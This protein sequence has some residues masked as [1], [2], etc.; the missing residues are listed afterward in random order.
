MKQVLQSKFLLGSLSSIIALHDFTSTRHGC[1][2]STYTELLVKGSLT[3]QPWVS[4]K[5]GCRFGADGSQQR[6]GHCFT[7]MCSH[8]SSDVSHSS[9]S[10]LLCLQLQNGLNAYSDLEGPFMK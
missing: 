4:A 8:H 10:I 6:L 3:L 7:M 9:G 2:A 1:V 5:A